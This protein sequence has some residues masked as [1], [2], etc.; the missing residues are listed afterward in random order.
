MK[1][2]PTNPIKTNQ[3]KRLTNTQYHKTVQKKKKNFP[4]H[5]QLLEMLVVA[6]DEALPQRRWGA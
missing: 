3:N 5:T 2:T 4:R 6:G 1:T